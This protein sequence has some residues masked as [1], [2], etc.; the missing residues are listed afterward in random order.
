[1]RSRFSIDLYVSALNIY[2]NWM[3]TVHLI[4]TRANAAHLVDSIR[5]LRAAKTREWA[6]VDG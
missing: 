6:S 4:K 2:N 1:M 3:Q 5:E